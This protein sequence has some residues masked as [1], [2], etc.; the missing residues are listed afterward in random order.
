MYAPAKPLGPFEIDTFWFNLS[1]IW[2][3][4]IVAFL[5]LYYD[6]L[7]K[8]MNAMEAFRLRRLDK[9]IKTTQATLVSGQNILRI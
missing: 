5:V 1:V 6:L 2:I 3:M 4:T 8:G 7:R 9:F